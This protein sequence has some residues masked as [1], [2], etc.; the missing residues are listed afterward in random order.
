VEFAISIPAPPGKFDQGE[1]KKQNSKGG[2]GE[3]EV[4]S[5]IICRIAFPAASSCC[6]TGSCGG[7]IM[8]LETP[9]EHFILQRG[10]AA[11][12]SPFVGVAVAIATRKIQSRSAEAND[13]VALNDIATKQDA[14]AD[15]NS[16]HIKS[17]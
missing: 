13:V 10:A 4:Q 14:A 11:A 15:L 6:P 1:G 12:A 5:N 17:N 2:G 8:V 7:R 3:L 9:R 16:L